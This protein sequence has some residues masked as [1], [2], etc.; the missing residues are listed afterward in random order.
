MASRTG[1]SVLDMVSFQ[2]V[3]RSGTAM[4]LVL[5]AIFISV[6]SWASFMEW[7]L[8]SP[9]STS[10]MRRECD[11]ACTGEQQDDDLVKSRSQD[12]ARDGEVAVRENVNPSV[13]RRAD[14]PHQRRGRPQH[15]GVTRATPNGPAPWSGRPAGTPIIGAFPAL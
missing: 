5:H 14:S 6:L 3:N 8:P 10:A 15:V 13:G 9:R 4:S 2:K 1:T 12:R 11:Q 7:L